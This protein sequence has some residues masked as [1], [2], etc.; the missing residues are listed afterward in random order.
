ML[1]NIY[2]VLRSPRS[3]LERI[4]DEAN[5]CKALNF[6]G[7]VLFINALTNRYDATSDDPLWLTLLTAVIAVPVAL[8]ITYLVAGLTHGIARMMGGQGTWKKLFITL[9]YCMIPQMIFIPIEVVLLL[10]GMETAVGIAALV[11]T[12]WSIVLGVLAVVKT[13]KLST[14]KSCIVLFAPTIIAFAVGM[15]FVFAVMGMTR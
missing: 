12:I 3:A 11:A 9:S 13:E 14:V 15:I 6:Q 2:D 1:T 5:I 8:A 4:N 10:F 7:I